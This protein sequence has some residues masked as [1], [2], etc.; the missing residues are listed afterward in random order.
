MNVLSCSHGAPVT[1]ISALNAYLGCQRSTSMSLTLLVNFRIPLLFT[2]GPEILNDEIQLSYAELEENAD[3]LARALILEQGVRSG[4]VVLIFFNKGIDMIIGILGILKSGAAYVPIDINHPAERIRTIHSSTSSKLCL[5]TSSLSTT[6]ASYLPSIL[7]VSVDSTLAATAIPPLQSECEASGEDLCYI[8]YTSG[9]TG[10]PKG[11]MVHHSAVVASVIDGPESNMM[12]RAEGL[13][14]QLR[15]LAF[16]NYAFDYSTWDIFLTLTSGGT[17][18]LVP[19]D[20]MLN[21]LTFVLNEMKI[22]FLETTPTVLGL[23]DPM[24]IPTLN[25]VYSSGEPLTTAV[26]D[27][28]LALQDL[29]RDL[30]FGNGGAPTETTVMSVFTTLTS[31][32]SDTDPRIFGKPFG[33]NSVYILDENKDLLPAGELGTLWI[34]GD[35]VSKG[36]LGR[37]DL[38]QAAFCEDIFCTEDGRSKMMYNTGDLCSWMKDGSGRLLH[39][40]RNDGQVKIRGQRVEVG[41]VESAIR[42]WGDGKVKNIF[43]LKVSRDNEMEVLVVFVVAESDSKVNNFDDSSLLTALHKTLPSYMVPNMVV[44]LPSL[45][46]TS[47]GKVD[48]GTLKRIAR[49]RFQIFKFAH[50]H[51]SGNGVSNRLPIEPAATTSPSLTALVNTWSSILNIPHLAVPLEM[52]FFSSGGDSI[53]AI[54]ACVMLRKMGFKIDY[55]DFVRAGTVR[56]QVK[57]MDINI[58]GEQ[59]EGNQHPVATQLNPHAKFSLVDSALKESV[60]SACETLYGYARDDIEDA[61][62]CTPMVAGLISIS[63]IRP[64]LY[65]AHYTYRKTGGYDPARMKAA[66][67]WL[68]R[69]HSILRTAALVTDKGIVQF[70]LRGVR[71]DDANPTSTCSTPGLKWTYGRFNEQIECDHAMDKYISTSSPGFQLGVYDGWC[72]PTMLQD[73][74]EAYGRTAGDSVAPTA[75]TPTP[76]PA[77]VRWLA[78]QNTSEAL[79]WWSKE[80]EGIQSLSWPESSLRIGEIPRTDELSVRSWVCGTRLAESCSSNGVTMSSFIQTALGLVLGMHANVQDVA[81]AVVTS[82]RSGNLEGIDEVVGPCIVTV[83]FCMQVPSESSTIGQLLNAVQKHSNVSSGYHHLVGLPEIQ[84]AN[85]HLI[86]NVLLTVENLPGLYDSEDELLGEHVLGHHLEM[87]YALAVTVFP[88]PDGRELRCQFEWDSRVLTRGDVDVFSAHLIEAF[89]FIAESPSSTSLTDLSIISPSEEAFLKTVASGIETDSAFAQYPF[90]QNLLDHIAQQYPT[91]IAIEHSSNASSITYHDLVKRSIQVA[92]GLQLRGIGPEAIVPVLFNKDSCHIDTIVA[93]VGIMKAGGAFVPLDAS[94]PADRLMACV[95]QTGCGF[96]ICDSATPDVGIDFTGLSLDEI[97]THAEGETGSSVPALT[98]ASLAYV[99][100]TSGS[101]GKPK[102]VMIEHRNIMAYIENGHTIFPLQDVK[103]ML[104]FCPYSFD[105]GLADIFFSVS[106]GAT[107]VLA[108]M[109]DMISDMSSVV[110]SSRVDYALMTPAVAQLIDTNKDYPCFRTLVVGG[111]KVPRQLSDAWRDKITFIDAYGPTE[112]TVHCV[113]SNHSASYPGPGVI[114][115]PLGCCQAYILTK[116]SKLAPLCVVGELCIAGP[117]LARGYL[118]AP[119]TTIAV[120]VPNP[121]S[122]QKEQRLY[123]TGDL[124]R[125]TSSGIIEYLGRKEGGYVKLNGL[126]IDLGEV[127]TALTSVD[128]TFA[129]VELV[130]D[131]QADSDQARLLAFVSRSVVVG[132]SASCVEISELQLSKNWVKELEGACRRFLP[133]H[134]IPT[135]WLVLDYIPQASTNKIDRKQL[136]ELWEKLRGTPDKLEEIHRALNGAESDNDQPTDV[137]EQIIEDIWKDLLGSESGKKA[138]S[139]KVHYDDFFAIGGDSIKMIMCLARFS[140]K[141]WGVTVKEFHEA[142]TI[143]KLGDIVKRSCMHID[144]VEAVLDPAGGLVVRVHTAES[145]KERAQNPIWFIHSGSGFI[146]REYGLLDPLGREIY[147]ISNPCVDSKVLAENYPTIDSFVDKYMPLIHP[148]NSIYLAGWSSGG[149]I[150][151]AL[152]AR[153]I[154]AGL[155][156]KGVILLDSSNTFGWKL[157]DNRAYQAPTTLWDMHLAHVVSLLETCVQPRCSAPVLL[158]RAE[159]PWLMPNCKWAYPSLKE[160]EREDE[161][162]ERNFYELEKMSNLT[163]EIG[164]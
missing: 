154:Q 78:Q 67:I 29:G 142:R 64:S 6:I 10:I 73:L 34:G 137:F 160:G 117:Q 161:R 16:S 89:K 104:H 112:A 24:E 25:V 52:N 132:G 83:P 37:E 45:P 7:V 164:E 63:T 138:R 124:A 28:F 19:M 134:M 1:R 143:A 110:R 126:R 58:Q 44:N 80:L 60:L 147:G 131:A 32:A 99:M 5:T 127:E 71:E 50:A 46:M 74:K 97:A 144:G 49:K 130:Q 72:L 20:I 30:R 69:K 86:L 128:K 115:R 96:L 84:K 87:N 102:G 103:R 163:V 88:S 15:T 68:I 17:L 152:A 22:T 76:Y 158:I 140:A 43:V 66:W 21:D 62:L 121:I 8:M 14:G 56:D 36:Y 26:R 109:T 91:R 59:L 146:S 12:L 100:F 61:Y 18:C 3:R 70:V 148:S 141:G 94:W 85:P 41:E 133:S 98:P 47:N 105:Q 136:R 54:Q 57:Q 150:A 108:D 35:Q 81:F 125:W 145:D 48:A 111:E 101:T 4:D 33:R 116:K 151:L 53:G 92:R 122:P 107:L 40:G 2:G 90:F 77:Y 55:S 51:A 123:R 162:L 39:H 27:K 9:S 156:V 135:I 95:K 153:R 93:F 120:F 113:S 82:G 38:T 149:N 42:K 79:N 114:G 11:V 118:E 106:V 31:H 157:I 23:I 75:T 119:D 139:L 129:V 159:T 155:P 65:M 13:K